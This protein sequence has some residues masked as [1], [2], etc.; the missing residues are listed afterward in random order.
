MYTEKD[1][2]G[3]KDRD[4]IVDRNKDGGEKEN[5]LIR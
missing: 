4:K 2:Q 3:K 1:N 5:K